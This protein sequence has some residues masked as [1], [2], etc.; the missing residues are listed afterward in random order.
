MMVTRAF[1]TLAL[2]GCLM[3]LAGC[4]RGGILVGAEKRPLSWTI[5][6]QGVIRPQLPSRR[7]TRRAQ[8]MAQTELPGP[9]T[10]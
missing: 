6:S 10:V 4:S 5:G 2:A 7:D 3:A 1:W 8:R 9:E